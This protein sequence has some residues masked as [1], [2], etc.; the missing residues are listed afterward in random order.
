[1]KSRN[2]NLSSELVKL[3]SRHQAWRNM[4]QPC[5]ACPLP[6]PAPLSHGGAH[7]YWTIVTSTLTL[8][9]SQ[10][11]SHSTMVAQWIN[12]EGRGVKGDLPRRMNKSERGGG[13]WF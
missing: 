1:M 9:L 10:P 8:P 11:F 2:V 3:A 7:F 13:W 4:M 12:Y 6:H 5:T